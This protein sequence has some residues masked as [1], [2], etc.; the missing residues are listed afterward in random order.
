MPSCQNCKQQFII[1]SDDFA[2]Y[3]KISVPPPTLCPECRMQR[4]WAWRNE[5]TLHRAT[6]AATGKSIISGFHPD[7]GYTIYDR[8][9]WW[10]DAWDAASFGMDY[11]PAKPFFQQFDELLHRVPMPA[12]FN[13]RTTNCSYTQHTGEY[14]DGYLVSA[15]WE[16]ENIAYASRCNKSKDSM[17]VYMIAESNF[18]YE[19]LECVKCSEVFFSRLAENCAQSYFLFNCKGCVNCFG[20]ENLRNKSYHIFNQPY[21]RE[22]YF[23][24][25]REFDVGSYAK[26]EEMK[27]R[28]ERI[29]LKSIRKFANFINVSNRAH[30]K[31]T[32]LK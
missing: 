2:F 12:V 1:E 15:S 16:G 27:T 26:L 11:D 5:R 21:S 6:C 4:R 10:S 28:F 13:S 3:A 7:A 17:D 14:K 25:L 19:D 20:C 8:D 30:F 23:T 29:K 24:K 31:T 9:Y 18:C 32:N 22:E